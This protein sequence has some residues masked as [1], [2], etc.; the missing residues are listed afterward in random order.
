MGGEGVRGREGRRQDLQGLPRRLGGPSSVRSLRQRRQ[1]VSWWRA[2]RARLLQLWAVGL[3]SSVLVT[4][5]SA[6][7][8]L[9]GWQARGLDLLLR[10][11]GHRTPYDVVVVAIDEAAFEGL[12]RRQP[13][14]R[15]YLARAARCRSRR[16]ARAGRWRHQRRWPCGQATCG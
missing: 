16:R 9:E 8:Y 4:A 1:A 6:L 2:R 13:I 15:D 12:G 5:A 11:Q 14:P 3:V 10:L 7:G